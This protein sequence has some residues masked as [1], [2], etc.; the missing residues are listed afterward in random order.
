MSISLAAAPNFAYKDA[1]QTDVTG[2]LSALQKQAIA[3]TQIQINVVADPGNQ[4]NGSAVWTY[5]VPDKVFDFL[6]A[7]ET[8]TLT[9][10]VRVDTNF[11]VSPESRLVPITITI[12]G[13]ND[14]PT[15]TTSGGTVIELVGTG[16]Q[17]LSTITGTVTF[18]D[19]DLTDRPIA[20]SHGGSPVHEILA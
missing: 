2:S 19:V 12:T 6:A 14:K 18:T 13:T 10:I 9:Y 5:T 8:L 15:V 3:A 1:G 7:G 20:I 11:T 17:A 4:N 16:N